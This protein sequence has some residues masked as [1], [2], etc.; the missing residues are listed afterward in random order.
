MNQISPM[1][2]SEPGTAPLPTLPPEGGRASDRVRTD[3]LA[4]NS[5]HLQG[6]GREGGCNESGVST[7]EPTNPNIRYALAAL[8]L[9]MLMPSLDTSIAQMGLPILAQ[10]FG[11]SFQAVQWVV[12]SYL[13]TIT[14]LIV[15]A[16]RLGD[17]VGRRRLL[18]GGVALFTLASLFCGLAQDL[19]QLIVA[20]AVQGIGAAIM[21]ALT[22][23]MVGEI[24]PKAR[25]GSA[26]GLLG[27][28][29]AIGTCMGPSL[30]GALI[31][32]FG[33]R[34]IFLVNIPVGLINLALAW[35]Y[36][37]RTDIPATRPRFDIPGT[38]VLAATLAAYALAMT[39]GEGHFT[40]INL[41][42][43]VAAVIGIVAFIQVQARVAAPLLRLAMF[44]D[45]NLSVGLTSNVIVFAVIVT[46]F[47]V[48]PF[49]L[50]HVLGLTPGEM[51]LAMSAGPL[52]SASTGIPAGRLVDRL[53]FTTMTRIGLL[54]MA[55][56]LIA[57]IFAP[58]LFGVAGYVGANI[59]VTAH[60][61]LYQAANNTSLM[62]D[63]APEQ[64]GIVG[65][66]VSL[67]RNLGLVT[68]AAMLGAVFAIAAGGDA[69]TAA[70]GDVAFAMR[71]TFGTAAGMIAAALALRL[72]QKRG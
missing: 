22:T 52:V 36:L 67:S 53:G 66:M 48:G 33:W 72:L 64:R 59:L 32:G 54:G 63:V 18:L 29:S 46:T 27:T 43:L 17:I 68:G 4:P 41:A 34:A 55:L 28:M 69:T 57:F 24:V 71:V 35:K 26:M 21:M 61:A 13:L 70:A 65:G 47:I 1:K 14:T 30:G 11:A 19:P 45:R 2:S 37:P 58:G 44:R 15:S 62:R 20:R 7:P 38:I 42:L 25:T 12:L 10:G 51:G 49:Y 56:G 31:S 16:G 3:H 60:Y 6:G 23:A 40:A 39:W 50:T 5:S 9:S 8:C